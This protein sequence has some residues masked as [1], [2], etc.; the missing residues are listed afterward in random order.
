[1]ATEHHSDASAGKALINTLTISNWSDQIKPILYFMRGQY[2][3]V[4]EALNPLTP[5]WTTI[6]PEKAIHCAQAAWS[7]E[8]DATKSEMEKNSP[9][10]FGMFVQCLEHGTRATLE[11]KG[12]L[13]VQNFDFVAA[14]LTI[15]R[16]VANL[17]VGFLGN[18]M[19][20]DVFES[21]MTKKAAKGVDPAIF[22]A[23]FG[24]LRSKMST[25]AP[26]MTEAGYAAALLRAFRDNGRLYQEI[27]KP[28]RMQDG[29]TSV[30]ALSS[31]ILSVTAWMARTMGR[32]KIGAAAYPALDFRALCLDDAEEVAAVA[33]VESHKSEPKSVKCCQY[34][35][36]LKAKGGKQKSDTHEA[37]D[38][39]GN[40][41][42]YELRRNW[43]ELTKAVE[44]MESEKSS[45]KSKKGERYSNSTPTPT[46]ALAHYTTVEVTKTLEIA[47]K[48][49]GQGLPRD[50]IISD[51]G[52]SATILNDKRWFKNLRHV[53]Y[54]VSGVAGA[55]SISDEGDTVFGVALYSEQIQV[56]LVSTNAL[57]KRHFKHF[58]V[59]YDWTANKF[60][61]KG[62]EVDLT[63][64]T[65]TNIPIPHVKMRP[66]APTTIIPVEVQ[67]ANHAAHAAVDQS[68][69]ALRAAQAVDLHRKLLH[70]PYATMKRTLRAGALRTD[71]TAGD[72]SHA[73][74]V[75]GKCP[76]CISGR[77]HHEMRGG[78]YDPAEYPG[79][80]L[81]CDT[82][83]IRGFDGVKKPFL[84]SVDERT[85]WTHLTK[86]NGTAAIDLLAA[87]RDVVSYLRARGHEVRRIY[88]DDDAAAKANKT[89]LGLIGVQLRQWAAA[90]HEPVAE[91]R[92]RTLTRDM[93][94][95]C[96]DLPFVLPEVCLSYCAQD[97]IAM[98]SLVCN[99]KTGMETPHTLIEDVKPAIQ[100]DS[101]I[102]FGAIVMSS[103]QTLQ[104]LPLAGTLGHAI[105][106][107]RHPSENGKYTV[108]FLHNQ[109]F[110]ERQLSISDVVEPGAAVY[111]AINDMSSEPYDID[112]SVTSS[113][114]ETHLDRPLM[115]EIHQRVLENNTASNLTRNSRRSRSRRAAAEASATQ[116]PSSQP[117]IDAQSISAPVDSIPAPLPSATAAGNSATAEKAAQS[118]PVKSAGGGAK[119]KKPVKTSNTKESERAQRA[120]EGLAYK[121]R[122]RPVTAPEARDAASDDSDSNSDSNSDSDEFHTPM[123]QPNAA[124]QNEDS[125]SDDS[126][127]EED[128]QP[129]IRQPATRSVEEA[130]QSPRRSARFQS[131]TP[132]P[133]M[134][135]RS[136]DTANTLL[137]GKHN[138]YRSRRTNYRKKSIGHNGEE[139]MMAALASRL[140][141]NLEAAAEQQRVLAMIMQ[142]NQLV[143]QGEDGVKAARKEIRNILDSG[144]LRPEHASKLT[145]KQRKESITSFLFG[146]RKLSGELKGRM[147]ENGKQ[148]QK[149]P[150]Y[151]NLFSPTSNPLTTMTHLT[152]ASHQRR[153][154][155]F[156]VDFPGAY[157]KVDR[158]KHNMPVEFTR[159][160]G[161]LAKLFIAEEPS[162]AEYMIDGTI[163][164]ELIK[165]VYGLTESAALWYK[166]L[167]DMLIGL[168]YIQQV[169]DPCLFIHPTL[170]SSINIHVDDCLVTCD[171]DAEAAR[172]RAFFETHKCTIKTD[173][174]TFLGMDI[175]RRN[176]GIVQVSMTKF[177]TALA[178]EWRL[179]GKEE[180]PTRADFAENDTSGPSP[181]RN[182]FVSKVMAL[183]YAAIRVRFDIL[184]AVATLSQHC[185]AP[186]NKQYSDLEHLL[187][188]VNGTLDKAIT[189]HTDS[190]NIHV[191]ADAS[192]MTHADRKG[193]T[194]VAVTLGE[195]GPCIAPKSSKAKIIT[196]S[197]TES[198]SLAAF[199]ATPLLQQTTELMKAFRESSIPILHQDNQ[200]AIAMAESGGGTSKH[201]KH[202]DLRLK[203]LQQLISDNAMHI[204]FTPTERMKADVFTKNITGKKFNSYM[205]ALM[206]K[207]HEVKREEKDAL[208]AYFVKLSMPTLKGRARKTHIFPGNSLGK[209][210]H[211][212]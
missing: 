25:T 90:Q 17:S 163:Y 99:V 167:R 198:E 194:G 10:L 46:S 165:S 117:R 175:W 199:E 45:Y 138:V 41:W 172:L 160:T 192:F 145:D 88:H 92:C 36:R 39:D 6:A 180:Y 2:G 49:H 87:E 182:E 68:R 32:D 28:D 152:V 94:T 64:A 173:D 178:K 195:H 140:Q 37:F 111:D 131:A 134:S 136:Q 19:Q 110:G 98:R 128:A 153:K 50:I 15:R 59:A 191:W 18:N 103:L 53:N 34:C 79:E 162:L 65:T 11:I 196:L 149:R 100:L 189:L 113:T 104:G 7:N 107:R 16:E 155:V 23:E 8:S 176:D 91:N 21:L 183:L 12:A 1:M 158:S 193:Q 210:I 211:S 208:L 212:L 169:V 181:R 73:E 55:V 164:F 96:L 75:W 80:H 161:Q 207:K 133:R 144:A 202:F 60:Q 154:H 26:W 114:S 84:L 97:C 57:H 170:K 184:F 82:V 179:T 135:L 35:Q 168:G 83:F 150:E 116:R 102:P 93:R 48:I 61:V 63:F 203:Y 89:E 54:E 209:N 52:A 132:Q 69:A 106:V 30:A 123:S 130:V 200:S 147:V 5:M 71:L 185:A 126:S 118:Q 40:P 120:D 43:S 146:K 31:M 42:C 129:V 86:M 112:S 78:Q 142:L 38:K 101:C 156:S 56:N 66:Q 76:A 47:M 4:A 108:F 109:S 122:V 121:P 62:P 115:D 58:H 33:K 139:L 159:I 157:L 9:K 204:V 124:P 14:I 187:R 190:L 51:P 95:A 186:T 166:E 174:F 77:S 24:S 20:T 85:S 119:V 137:Q 70:M 22:L 177:L 81:R 205:E 125:S 44:E 151:Q 27:T 3:A 188:Y 13:T 72:V 171:N 143:Q 197:S 148:L 67:Q 74:R 105:V 201:T 141:P 29:Y 127:V 206:C